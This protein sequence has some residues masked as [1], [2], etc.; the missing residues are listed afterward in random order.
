M[1][2]TEDARGWWEAS[3]EES[4]SGVSKISASMPGAEVF[5]C[6]LTVDTAAGRNPAVQEIVKQSL[7]DW[8]RGKF[9][10][11]AHEVQDGARNIAKAERSTEGGIFEN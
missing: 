6:L 5:S 9:K 1:I 11:S 7:N 2:A 8:P 3:L 10:R 4:G